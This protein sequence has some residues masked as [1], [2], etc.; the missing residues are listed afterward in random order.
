MTTRYLKR[1]KPLRGTGSLISEGRET[2]A[3]DYRM[4]IGRWMVKLPD[5]QEIAGTWH[6]SG[7][8]QTEKRFQDGIGL[9]NA[10]QLQLI[11]GTRVVVHFAQTDD[12]GTKHSI[13]IQGDD[14]DDLV[15]KYVG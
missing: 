5:G 12:T 10:Y 1:I 14:A 6:V 7:H 13:Y 3:V 9:I 2:V 8:L 15:T 11:D 4:D